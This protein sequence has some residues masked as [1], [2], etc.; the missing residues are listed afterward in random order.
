[1]TGVLDVARPQAEDRTTDPTRAG[2]RFW[3]RWRLALMLG[4]RDVTHHKVR[5]AL[6]VVMVALAT[7][8]V[9]AAAAA[10]ALVLTPGSK[11]GLSS[12]FDPDATTTID[13]ASLGVLVVAGALGLAQTL[14]LVAPAFLISLRRRTRELGLLT[15]AGAR[16]ADLRRLVVGPA[17]VSALIGVGVGGPVALFLV[18]LSVGSATAAGALTTSLAVVGVMALNTVL[19]VLAAWLPARSTLRGS[20]IAA[21]NG[22]PEATNPA[23]RQ[24]TWWA[25]GA[26]GALAGGVPLALWGAQRATPSPMVAGVVLAEAGVLT[27][28]GTL[29]GVLGRLPSRGVVTAYV[30]RDAS[31]A[32]TRVLPAVAAGTIIVAAATAGLAY[33]ATMHAEEAERNYVR[34]APLGSAF[35]LVTEGAGE[36]IDDLGDTASQ[37]GPIRAVTP[38]LAAQSPGGVPGPDPTIGPQG[39]QPAF[40]VGSM[41]LMSGPLIATPDLVD[42]LDLGRDA[43]AAVAAGKVLVAAGEPLNADGTV[44]LSIADRALDAPAAVVPELGR[45]TRVALTP[46]AATSLGLEPAVV[47]AIITP[48]P[49]F[50]A[51]DRT[52]VSEVLGYRSLVEIGPPAFE[53]DQTGYLLAGFGAL[54]VLVVTAVMSALAAQETSADR[55]TLEAIGAAPRTT[56]RIAGAQ[57]WLIA[58]ASAWAGVPAGFALATLLLIAQHSQTYIAASVPMATTAPWG[59]VLALLLGLPVTVGVLGALIPPTG[60][61]AAKVGG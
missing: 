30:L 14:V 52:R 57:A 53:D 16:D 34:V 40:A 18:L 48:V 17:L 3:W 36:S 44:H 60:A 24:D 22:R 56:R 15:A 27:L 10:I 11:L 51:E 21:L 33:S 38:V 46:D 7:A 39:T 2:A 61:D 9:G 45:Y 5:T 31:R 47:G 29:L 1:M 59:P 32:R 50:T 4:W 58:A 49:A 20:P 41:L 54:A 37:L 25:I 35:V 8:I 55:S 28:L 26:L 23:R 6:V 19:A 13:D 12:S 42:A 43:G